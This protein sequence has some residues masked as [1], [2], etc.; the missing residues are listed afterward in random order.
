[1]DL[2]QEDNTSFFFFDILVLALALFATYEFVR[3]LS[4]KYAK[5]LEIFSYLNILLGYGAFKL[6][7]ELKE[8]DAGYAMIGYMSVLLVM[9]IGSCA[10]TMFSKN[11][12]IDNALSTIFSMIYPGTIMAFMI[13]LNHLG[14]NSHVAILI[15]FVVTS[16]TDTMA[17]L[18]GSTLKGKK[19]CPT[20]SPNKTISG[21]IG[22][23]LGGVC[24]GVIIYFIAQAG[25]L[26]CVPLTATFMSNL[27]NFVFLGLGTSIFCQLGDLISSYIKRG[28]GIKDFGKIL[29]GHGGFM[30]RIDGL[31]ISSVFIF[32]YLMLMNLIV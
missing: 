25:V 16:L 28:C 11:H 18:V 32:I 15:A 6:L 27:F 31:I 9:V 13:G 12:N 14:A 24:G 2:N 17:Y 19:L 8:I 5:P 3:A 22:G 20:I 21:A 30:D 26:K 4:V 7:F 23:L 10:F 29:K 1:M